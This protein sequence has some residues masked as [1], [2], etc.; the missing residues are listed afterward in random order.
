MGDDMVDDLG[1]IASDTAKQRR[2][3]RPL[4][5]QADEVQPRRARDN[6][7]DL[8]RPTSTGWPPDERQ[9]NRLGRSRSS[10]LAGEPALDR[11][12]KALRQSVHSISAE[13]GRRVVRRLV[14][15]APADP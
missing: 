11:R 9:G 3:D 8:V 4:E 6:S 1:G 13:L 12:L 10:D 2:R 5:R 15:R 14:A 7:L